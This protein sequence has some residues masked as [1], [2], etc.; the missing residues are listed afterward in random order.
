MKRL[1]SLFFILCLCLS[2]CGSGETADT[3][4]TPKPVE[5]IDIAAVNAVLDP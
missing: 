2:G 4:A 3:P 5:Y 1:L